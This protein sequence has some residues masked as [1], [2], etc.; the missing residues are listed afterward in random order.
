VHLVFGCTIAVD[1]LAAGTHHC[2]GYAPRNET[3]QLLWKEGVFIKAALDNYTAGP[4]PPCT[5]V[6]LGLLRR[7]LSE[8]RHVSHKPRAD[9]Y[10]P[11]VFNIR[12]ERERM[13]YR[14]SEFERAMEELFSTGQIKVESYRGT[15]RMNYEHI[16]PSGQNSE[17]DENSNIPF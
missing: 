13:A 5:D 2:R 8:G 11:K 4:P 12:P 3:L 10:A 9:N 17:N 7:I 16:V 15:D 6:F 1:P 14:K